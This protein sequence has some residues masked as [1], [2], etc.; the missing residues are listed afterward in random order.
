M[1]PLRAADSME[2]MACEP[3]WTPLACA[4]HA[5]VQITAAALSSMRVTV[6]IVVP[7]GAPVAAGAGEDAGEFSA[8]VPGLDL[9]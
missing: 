2:S 7:A 3:L 8:V 5:P 9:K 1:T 6:A 4:D